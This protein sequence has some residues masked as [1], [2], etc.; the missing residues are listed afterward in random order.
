ME[1]EIFKKRY[2]KNLSVILKRFFS[3]SWEKRSS[4]MKKGREGEEEGVKE[5]DVKG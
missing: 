2:L 1:N 4:V 5:N 3:D